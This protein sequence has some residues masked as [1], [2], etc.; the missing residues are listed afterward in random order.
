MV[1][2]PTTALSTAPASP[3]VA[4]SPRLSSE[5]LRAFTGLPL[6]QRRL[7]IGRVL[8]H[9]DEAD[10]AY[11]GLIRAA[12]SHPRDAGIQLRIADALVLLQRRPQALRRYARASALTS[13]RAVRASALLDSAYS[14]QQFAVCARSARARRSRPCGSGGQRQ[15]RA[16]RAARQ[17]RGDAGSNL[18]HVRRRGQSHTAI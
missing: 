13:Q 16:N 17:D 11:K 8:L 14:C 12:R 18:R 3:V 10:I 1:Q 5:A 6:V 4:A 9:V 15:P 2:L 7:A